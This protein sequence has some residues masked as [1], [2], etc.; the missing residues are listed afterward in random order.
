MCYQP[1]LPLQQSH[2]AIKYFLLH[3]NFDVGSL[4]YRHFSTPLF[5][6]S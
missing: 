4:Q 2:S 3:E 6:Q 5:S 1:N